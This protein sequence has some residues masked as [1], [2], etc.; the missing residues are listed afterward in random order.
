MCAGESCQCNKCVHGYKSSISVLFEEGLEQ[1]CIDRV[2]L[3]N[4]RMDMNI[5]RRGRDE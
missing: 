3:N 5:A 4:K 2:V 1:E